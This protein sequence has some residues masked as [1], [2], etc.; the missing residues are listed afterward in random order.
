MIKAL[1]RLPAWKRM[2][3]LTEEIAELKARVTALEA[4]MEPATG[5]KCP[6]CGVMAFGLLRSQRDPRPFGDL[7]AMQDVYSCTNCSYERIDN[8]DPA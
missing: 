5:A 2:T 4:A 3:A 7:G 1:E 8:R 6:K